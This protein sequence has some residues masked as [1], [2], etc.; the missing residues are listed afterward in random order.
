MKKQRAVRSI[1]I[2]FVFIFAVALQ[3]HVVSAKSETKK[4]VTINIGQKKKIKIKTAKIK[5]LK[6]K[7]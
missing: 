5:K 4:N 7:S 3:S 2:C 6:V 1:L